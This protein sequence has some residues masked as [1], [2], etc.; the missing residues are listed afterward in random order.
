MADKESRRRTVLARAAE[1]LVLGVALGASY[2]WG[3]WSSRGQPGTSDKP[4]PATTENAAADDFEPRLPLAPELRGHEPLGRE[5]RA[6]VIRQDA[7][8]IAK[9]CRS[10]GG[11]WNAWER[12]T[13]GYRDAL[14][15]RVDSLKIVSPNGHYIGI[16]TY[17]PLPGRDDFPLF[18]IAAKY[19]LGYLTDAS[20]LDSFRHDRAVVAADR[21]LR[22]RGIDLIFVPVPRMTEVYIEN[23]L[24]PCPADGI[25][26]PHLRHTLLELFEAD[27]EVVDCFRALRGRREPAPDYLYNTADT[28]WAPR[29]MRIV[30]KQIADRIERY[31]FG[32]QARYAL[33]KFIT[34]IAPYGITVYTPDMGADVSVLN[35][36]STLSPEQRELA[37]KFQTTRRLEVSRPDGQPVTRDPRSPVMVIGNSYTKYF[38]DQLARELNLAVQ[39]DT[40]DNSTTQAFANFLRDPALLANCRVVVWI[41]TEYDL[42]CFQPMPAP[43]M[44]A[45]AN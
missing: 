21:W 28:H 29:G 20:A 41:T 8:A 26:A 42:T 10:A 25:I 40:Q 34:T 30:A 9:E 4:R 7:D 14:K 37:A 11:D 12:D 44:A 1:M 18:E 39:T 23:F 6:A 13:G 19:H 33:P 17:A 16:E 35:G 36:W 38:S 3:A 5:A 31:R 45:L 24:E 22:K 43:I 32:S 27:V 15:S 2:F